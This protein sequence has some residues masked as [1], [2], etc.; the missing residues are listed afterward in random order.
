MK[1]LF[2]TIEQATQLGSDLVEYAAM[3]DSS[4]RS[5]FKG[6]EI[7]FGDMLAKELMPDHSFEVTPIAEFTEISKDSEA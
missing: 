6:F 3:N 1:K 5:L 4:S 7:S 2:I